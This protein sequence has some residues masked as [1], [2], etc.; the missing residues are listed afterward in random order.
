[1]EGPSATGTPSSSDPD[2]AATRFADH[3]G[4]V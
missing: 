2:R 1:M 4:R 3:G